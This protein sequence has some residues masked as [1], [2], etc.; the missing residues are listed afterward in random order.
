M[1]LVEK[2]FREV[3]VDSGSAACCARECKEREGSHRHE[4]E[5]QFSSVNM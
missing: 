4:A 3:S 2:T 5:F 1:R